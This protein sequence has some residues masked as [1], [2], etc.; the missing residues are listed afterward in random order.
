[1]PKELARSRV[2]LVPKKEVPMLVTDYRPISVC[3]VTYKIISK[4]LSKRLQPFIPAM[5]SPTQTAFTPG[6]Q[7]GDNII[8]LREVLHSFSLKSY[9]THSFCLKVDLS[10][11]FDRMRWSF[12]FSVLKMHGMPPNYIRW[13]TACV[14]SARFSILVNGSADG[15]IQPTNGLRQGCALSPYLFIL[16]IDVLSR[17]LQFMVNEGQLKGVKIARGSPVLT[18]LMYADD[19]LIFGEASY[20]EV[21][22]LNNT[23]ALF[24][25]ISGQ[26]I[27]EDKSWIWF[28]N[29]TP[30]HIR[31]FTVHTFR[32][33]LAT[34]AEVY[35]GSPITATRLTD[36]CPLL[37][38]I[39]HK[40]QNWKSALLSQAGKMVLIKSVVEPTMLYAMQTS[41]LPKS[42]LKK[43]QS[44]IRSFFWNNGTEKRMSLLAWKH[45]T[46]P[47]N[48]GGLGLKDLVKFTT[49][50]HMKYLWHLASGTEA[51]WVHI[52]KTKYLQRADLWSTKRT[53][54]CTPMWRAILAV[55]PVLK[56]N[57]RW[58][59]ENGKKC[60]A[61][62]Q[63]W[64]DLWPHYVP[65]NAAQR[66]LKLADLVGEQGIGWNTEKL[67]QAF[68][69]HGA[70]Y[71]A[72]TFP[73]GPSL[74]DRTDRL[75]F[76]P[77]KNGAFT[78]KEA[79]KLLIQAPMVP[80]GQNNIY[81]IIWNTPNILPRSRL[82]IWKAV[83]NALPVDHILSSRINK[84]AQGCALC[85]Y[86]REDV[87]HTLF[88]CP[89]AQQVW[90]CS[91]FGLR[92]DALPEDAHQLLST[93]LP[94]LSDKQTSSF[95]SLCWQL[96]KGRCKEVYEG[97]KF[98]PNQIIHVAR[99]LTFTLC[100]AQ[101]TEGTRNHIQRPQTQDTQFVCYSDGSWIHER[102][103]G[104]GWAY[105]I[106][107]R[108][109]TLIQ[110]Q[111]AVGCASSPFHAELK[112]LTFAVQSAADI[113]LSNCCFFTDCLELCRVINGDASVATV[114]WRT[115][116]E[117]LRLMDLM[118]ANPGYCCNHVGRDTNHLA[119]NLAK[120][121]RVKRINCT[122]FT[123][124]VLYL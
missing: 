32:A 8:I 57:I 53:A 104:A 107:T 33:K 46:V 116:H 94:V 80:P 12:I 17:L 108:E 23:L 15:F 51:L 56:G 35:L 65:H 21:I 95:I 44:R 101:Y 14:T 13:I 77:A 118:R 105:I 58:Q 123:F 47:K 11:A 120:L 84:T 25:E 5:V 90:L 2:V 38:K 42:V 75:I 93:L 89:R 78:I 109:E 85:G 20:E 3:N 87:V 64:H 113:G 67:I 66:R 73:S 91:E 98:T 45:I 52:I 68:D 82:F 106:F 22:E 63:P 61:I 76:T 102:E 29:N 62:G 115:Y 59:I 48:Q 71:I 31:E 60:G 110:Y 24:C 69:F 70:L 72:L 103:G 43:I 55:R 1:M 40:L 96:W 54:R 122:D 37:N 111:L 41:V 81:N 18:S 26:E 30:N 49:S 6:R 27:G 112:G 117:M 7:I 4:L 124:P 121:A 9:T 28:S 100:S 88:K 74:T 79:Y 50:V 114:E 10:K 99:N 92:T 86:R 97:K 36:F 16:A 19:L 39:E 119:D 83:R 34:R